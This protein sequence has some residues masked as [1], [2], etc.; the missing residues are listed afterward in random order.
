[1]LQS[2]WNFVQ[3]KLQ[4]EQSGRNSDLSTCRIVGQK[5]SSQHNRRMLTGRGNR[6]F[7]DTGTST[8]S[9][10]L[11]GVQCIIDILVGGCDTNSNEEGIKQHCI[12]IGVELNK[13]EHLTTKSEWY[14][15]YK[16]YKIYMKAGDREKFMKP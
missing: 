16:I 10:N 6:E 12:S 14:E 4:M 5:S 8:V 3:R 15:V 9:A 11:N 2:G 1:M 7:N 13:V